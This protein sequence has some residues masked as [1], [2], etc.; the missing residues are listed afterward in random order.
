MNVLFANYGDFAT[1]STSHIA[2]FANALVA[3]GHS[4]VVGVP[5]GADT[6]RL[7]PEVRFKAASFTECLE[8]GAPF[9][10]GRPADIVHA[11]TPREI[12]REFVLA[13]CGRN[14]ARLV[15][16]L[17]DNEDYLFASGTGLPLEGLL[18]LDE[19]LI[20]QRLN[21]G[22]SHPR[23][24][25]LLLHTADGVTSIVPTLRAFAP[26]ALPALDLP[27][28]VDFHL[29]RPL[30]PM[31]HQRTE[32]GFRD[33]EKC[34]VYTGSTSHANAA[35]TRDL[36]E[37]V[38]LLNRRGIATRLIRTGADDPAFAASI[39]DET[40]AFVHHLGF[41]P[42][43]ELPAL[44]AQ[45]DVLVQ[46]GR[47]GPFNDFRLPSKIPEYL[48][49]G[50]PVVLPASN[51]GL[52]L[53]HE[54]EALVLDQATPERIADAC[55]RVFEDHQLARRLGEHGSSFARTRFDGTRQAER[56]V[57]FYGEILAR[58]PSAA[59]AGRLQSGETEVTLALM[60]LAGQLHPPPSPDVARELAALALPLVRVLVRPDGQRA[61]VD[62]AIR[63]RDEWRRNFERAREHATNLEQ[64]LQEL[65]SDIE[66]LK[67]ER[68]VEVDQLRQAVA[69]RDE[70]ISRMTET[71]SWQVTKPL[72]AVRRFVSGLFRSKRP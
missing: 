19:H 49:T 27:P 3:Q 17:E 41:I 1:N 52:E 70:K 45:A 59:A 54:R 22:L 69:Q 51:I 65:A 34:I 68:A 50:R 53:A 20:R 8:R 66:A 61:D 35:E 42:R 40:R 15:I 36:Y 63:E 39:S 60:R 67:F 38:T 16:H 37:A 23:R 43:T 31:P 12:V 46:P 4:C 44:L 32:L 21:S 18:E 7:V 24:A 29:F 30:E 71:V 13:Y 62:R 28:G 72:R 48:A 10:D 56:L 5:W 64:R 47:P 11:W 58:P 26:D 14:H 25:R 6:V 2:G 33:G 55:L 57:G 9:P